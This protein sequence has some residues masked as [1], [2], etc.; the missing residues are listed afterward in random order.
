MLAWLAGLWDEQKERLAS[1]SAARPLS[2]EGS[3]RGRISF[4][5][6]ATDNEW[7]ASRAYWAEDGIHPNDEGYRIWGTHIGMD[8]LRQG[9][10]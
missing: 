6:N 5:K 7:W 4:V 9:V 2:G 1:F 3:G 8:I 10:L